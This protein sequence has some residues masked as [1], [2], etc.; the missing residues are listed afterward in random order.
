MKGY[1]G[2]QL[3]QFLES[4]KLVKSIGGVYYLTDKLSSLTNTIGSP[5][6]ALKKFCEDIE[7][8]FQVTTPNGQKY[9]VKYVTDRIGKLYV[10]VLTEVDREKLVA[11]TKKYY[12][13]TEYPVTIKNYFEQN[14][15][16]S[17]LEDFKNTPTTG[18]S[19]NKFES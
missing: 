2:I 3:V 6:D 15:W 9:T 12:K 1:S 5:K 13:E 18:S 17:A 16:E 4:N 11:V 14:V 7:L 10:A 8:P 19:H